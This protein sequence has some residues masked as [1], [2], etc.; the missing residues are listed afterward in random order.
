MA[1]GITE[2]LGKQ[3]PVAVLATP[4]STKF[5]QGQSEALGGEIGATG[6]FDH[7]KAAQ[8]HDEFKTLRTGHGV[9]TDPLVTILEVPRGGAP[10]QHGNW[11]TF[12]QHELAQAITC[13]PAR[14]EQMLLIK[15]LMGDGPIRRALCN[16]YFQHSG[17]HCPLA[18]H[19]RGFRF[20]EPNRAFLC[21]VV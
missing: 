5:A 17:G 20:H 13:L 14:T 7:Q 10:H 11:L 4:C 1:F 18:V 15:H 3:G 6:G 21:P 2:T 12:L 16:T 9:P 19:D 8:L